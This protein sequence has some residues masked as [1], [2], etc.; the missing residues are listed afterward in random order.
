MT[1]IVTIGGLILIIVI[2]GV[3]NTSAQQQYDPRNL[4]LSNSNIFL[5][6]R[7]KDNSVDFILNKY[8]VR[9]I[10]KEDQPLQL[11]K[12]FKTK[13]FIDDGSIIRTDKTVEY[14][15]GLL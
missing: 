15:E 12:G 6:I 7:N 2:M 10:M 9:S 14:I 5:K 3:F 13:I 8:A 11:N 1:K 4:P